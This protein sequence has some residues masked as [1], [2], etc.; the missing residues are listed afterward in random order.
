M[1]RQNGISR[2]HVLG[3]AVTVGGLAIAG[4]IRGLGAQ[5]TKQIEQLTPELEKILSTSEPI[6]ELADGFGGAQ[7]PAEGPLWWKEGGYLL[8]SDIHNNRRMKYT[9]GQGVSVFQEPTN[10]ANGLTRDLQGRLLAC[11]HDSRRVTRQEHDGS[12]TVIANSFQGRRLNRPN[13]VVV[14]S[15]GCIY[16]TD[17]WTNPLPQEQ[18]DLTFAG[19]YRVTPDLGTL[20]LLT[21]SFV[22]PNGLAFSPDE[23]VLYINDSRRRHIRAFDVLPNGTL[24]KQTDRV[25]ADLGGS[26]PGVPDGMKADVA[27]NVYCGGAGGIWIMDPQGKKLGRIV[28]GAPATTN[29]AFGGDDWKTLYFTSRTHL[30]AVKVKIAGLPVPTQKK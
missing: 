4:G 24:A 12:I 14:K 11:E 16:F 19:V 22:L 10:R 7:G 17:P 2:R 29:I 9:P 30:G 21:D 27:G 25:F 20:T 28:H 1:R 13:D 3:M 5:V 26:E 23:S 18:W 15:D 6:Q 8:F